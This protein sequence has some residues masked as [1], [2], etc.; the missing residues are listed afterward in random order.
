MS[1]YSVSLEIAGPFAMFAR[2]DAGGTPTSYP[3]PTQSAAKGIFESIARLASGDAWFEATKV[4]MCKDRGSV[5]GSVNFQRYATNYG[6]PLRKGNQLSSNSSYQLFA[7]VLT[8]VCYR[9]QGRIA[10]GDRPWKQGENPRHHLKDLFDR[11][12]ER[13]QCHRTPCL[14]WS[15]FTASY[16]GPFRDGTNGAP[17]ATEVDEEIDILIPSLLQQVFD[18]P[19]NGTFQPTF[20]QNARIEKGVF[21]YVE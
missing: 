1:D 20:I 19:T 2:P 16:W 15:E 17:H 14:G 4:K 13:G 11:R 9:L 7:T 5:G 12:L 18:R 10:A 6:G 3:I 21:R 8:G